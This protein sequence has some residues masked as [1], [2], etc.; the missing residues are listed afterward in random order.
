MSDQANTNEANQGQADGL[1]TQLR[2]QVIEG[3]AV[4]VA[5]A[6]TDYVVTP[7]RKLPKRIATLP[8]PAPYDDFTVTAWLNYPWALRSDLL[9]GD[10]A[11][12]RAAFDQILVGHDLVDFD[13]TPFPAGGSAFYDAIP[14][15]LLKV[16]YQTIQTN[17][18]KLAPTIAA[19]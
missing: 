9:S 3:E 4:P 17:V 19:R 7:I 15:D 14:E 10:E 1:V 6:A 16:I 5:A 18:G 13:G 2:P 8:L 12:A 11:K